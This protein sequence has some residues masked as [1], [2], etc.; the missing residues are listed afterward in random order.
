MTAIATRKMGGNRSQRS[1]TRKQFL[2]NPKNPKLSFNVYIDKNPC[3]TIPIHYK[4]VQDVENT[5]QKLEKLYK[6]HKYTHRRIWSVGMIMK[7][8]L[9]VLR[10]KKP[11]EY[12]LAK[13]YFEFLGE[14]TKM[15][16]DDRYRSVFKK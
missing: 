7:V 3:D 16:T 15:N 14:R 4:T 5:I 9:E 2:Y 12:A 6:S 11:E 8:R 1:R 10:D 13:R